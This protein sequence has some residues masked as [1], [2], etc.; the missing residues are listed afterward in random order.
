MTS[1]QMCL[2][3]KTPIC[4][5]SAPHSRHKNESFLAL[6]FHRIDF[7]VREELS[8][9]EIEQKLDAE[10]FYLAT[11]TTVSRNGILFEKSS[12]E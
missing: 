9:E 3:H 1:T 6:K 4:Q 10:R 8:S 11:F 12:L 2:F 5:H 7:F